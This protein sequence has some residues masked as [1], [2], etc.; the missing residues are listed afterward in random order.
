VVPVENSSEGAIG[1]TLDLLLQTPLTIN[2]EV[3]IAVRHSLM[4]RTGLMDGVQVICAHS[5]ALAQCQIWLNNN[6]PQL[7]R[8]AVS[9]NA[10]AA[11]MARDDATVAAIA[12]ER[13]GV[14]YGLGVVKGNI[15]DDPHN[16][17]RFAVIG[18]HPVGPSGKDRT[19]LALAVPNKAGAVYTLL[20]PLSQHGVS[21][22]RFES[23]PA[24]TGTWEYYFYVDIEGH[25]QTPAVAR[26]LADLQSNAAF[27]KV[28][29]SY[30]TSL[31]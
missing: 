17:T 20:A 11:R 4:T 7:E 8:R 24:R 25:V 3:A 12:G 2:G 31:T 5:Q 16:R 27:F 19:S 1:R 26:A 10:E 6:Y 29:G 21:M 14:Q 13:A 22:T 30:P 15:Q 18:Q 28:L 9:S 23:R